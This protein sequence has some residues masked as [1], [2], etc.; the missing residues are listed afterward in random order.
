[1]APLKEQDSALFRHDNSRNLKILRWA[2]DIFNLRYKSY[3]IILYILLK[4]QSDE[5]GH[6][7]AGGHKN[8]ARK[9][10][11]RAY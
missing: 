3:R 2:F 5:I 8:T 9:L 10:V 1:M 4:N 7:I 6:N 11:L